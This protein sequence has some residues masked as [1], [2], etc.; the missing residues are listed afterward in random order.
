MDRS[1]QW[2]GCRNVRDLGGL[3]RIGG[4]ETAFGRVVRSDHPNNLS[5]TGWAS[6]LAHGIRTIVTLTTDG[7]VLDGQL[8][9]SCPPGLSTVTAVV[10]DLAEDDF[11]TTW[12]D[13]GLWETPLYWPDALTRWPER[14]AAAVRAVANA[15]AGGVLVH[16]GRGHDRT[17]I[18]CALLLR[19]AGVAPD[20]IAD[21]YVLS[22]AT[23]TAAERE[24]FAVTM[25]E[26]GTT[27]RE[28]VLR[29]LNETDI[30]EVLRA[31]GLTDDDV[32]HLGHRLRP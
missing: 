28:A 7:V 29:V 15:E 26:H 4:G 18:V 21:D 14:H 11:R 16:C 20:A 17:G 30:S 25:S 13:S 3:P 9:A 23:L 22:Q 12:V 31:G 8:V 1:L 10:E 5:P 2:S 24:R 32:A 19:L 27:G 6:L